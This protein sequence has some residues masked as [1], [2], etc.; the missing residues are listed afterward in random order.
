M[1]FLQTIF[2]LILCTVLFSCTTEDEEPSNNASIVGNWQLASM[3]YDGVSRL[4]MDGSDME[5]SFSGEASEIDFIIDFS[6]SPNRFSSQG[7]YLINLTYDLMGQ[8][9]NIPVRIDDFMGD[10]SWDINGD[11]LK[12][13]MTGQP[14]DELKILKL[15][16]NELTMEGDVSRI[17]TENEALMGTTYNAIFT[18]KR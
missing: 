4:S 11:I 7:G 17:I 16:A 14:T 5:Q 18:F 8:D 13:T 9:I 6:E 3:K 12:V 15:T 1:K 2:F 10:G